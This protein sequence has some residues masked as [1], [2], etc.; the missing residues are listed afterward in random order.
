M[1]ARLALHSLVLLSLQNRMENLFSAVGLFSISSCLLYPCKIRPSHHT[2]Q[3]ANKPTQVS[4]IPWYLTGGVLSLVGDGGLFPGHTPH[5]KVL[6]RA[7]EDC[8]I[9]GSLC[10]KIDSTKPF[11]MGSRTNPL[12]NEFCWGV[13][14]MGN[15]VQWIYIFWHLD[16]SQWMSFSWPHLTQSSLEW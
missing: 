15:M 3:T 9:S 11:W 8:V 13:K 6:R 2:K 10:V 4:S 1:R 12:H 14:R 5:C 7:W 16:S